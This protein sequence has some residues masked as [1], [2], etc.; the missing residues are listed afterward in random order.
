LRRSPINRAGK[1]ELKVP[2]GRLSAELFERYERLEKAPVAARVETYTKVRRREKVKHI[3]VEL[4]LFS[5][6]SSRQINKTLGAGAKAFSEPYLT[7]SA[8]IVRQA[9]VVAIAVDWQGRREVASVDMASCESRLS[10]KRLNGQGRYGVEFR[11]PGAEERDCRSDSGC[12][13]AALLCAFFE[14][15]ARLRSARGR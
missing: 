5:A 10:W 11:P 9:V 1:L 14:E 3:T 6:S 13:L 15:C 12:C 7:A 4:V 2:R 8:T